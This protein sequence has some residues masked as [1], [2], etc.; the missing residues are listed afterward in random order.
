MASNGERLKKRFPTIL[1]QIEVEIVFTLFYCY[2]FRI[3]FS[4]GK[5]NSCWQPAIHFPIFLFPIRTA[6]L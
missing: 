6:K 5:L 4:K 3:Y 1:C 2:N